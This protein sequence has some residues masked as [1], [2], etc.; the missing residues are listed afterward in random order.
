[1]STLQIR[2]MPEDVYQALAFRADR[3]HRSLAQQAVI[4]L[5]Q[6]PELEASQ[7]RQQLLSKI[8][9]ELV[10]KANAGATLSKTPE[11]LQRED[12]DR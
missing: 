12:R 1:M 8:E 7:R 10:N 4:E 6:L 9:V 2:Q 3:A 5:R 11:A